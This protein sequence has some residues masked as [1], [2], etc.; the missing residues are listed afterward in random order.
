MVNGEVYMIPVYEYDDQYAKINKVKFKEKPNNI[1]KYIRAFSIINGRVNFKEDPYKY[2]RVCLLVVDFSK[3]TPKIY[4]TNQELIDDGLL[5]PDSDASI[6]GLS[7]DSFVDD[8]LAIYAER[9]G[10]DKFN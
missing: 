9:F 7:F 4:S 10:S 6:D 3:R 8:L 1:E 5:S 2:E